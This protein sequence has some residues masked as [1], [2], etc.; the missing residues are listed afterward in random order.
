M[1]T[2]AA[3]IIERDGKVLIARRKEVLTNGGRWEFP[4][5]KLKEGE[6]PRSCLK[7]EIKEELGLEVTVTDQ[8]GSGTH[9]S[10][11]RNI[12]LLFYRT[13]WVAGDICLQDHSEVRWVAGHQLREYDLT[14]ADR[15]FA[16]GFKWSEI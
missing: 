5:G 7:R 1:L 6:T 4:G 2:V 10:Q 11:G 15:Q 8:L 12:R 3:A 16:K 9:D 13:R 14:P